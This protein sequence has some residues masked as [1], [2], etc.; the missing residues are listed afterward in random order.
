MEIE[1]NIT[2]IFIIPTLKFPINHLTPHG[3]IN[4]YIK[5]LRRDIQYENAVYVLFKPL[6]LDK[7]RKFLDEEYERTDDIIDEY[8]YE[9]GFV[10]LV[11]KLNPKFKK[12]YKLV[13]QGMYSKTSKEYQNCFAKVKKIMV[14][15]L[16]RDELSLQYC[17]FNKTGNLKE[18]WEEKLNIR[19][20]EEWELWE[21]WEEELE[22]MDIDKIKEYEKV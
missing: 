13:M 6:D 17:A 22:V 21:G 8:D 19:F 3:F 11:Y 1:K 14:N 2:T 5:D 9:G 7:F 4:G 18:W 16:H 12:D 15:G 10:V 20:K